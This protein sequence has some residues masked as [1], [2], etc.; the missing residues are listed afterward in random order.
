M[1]VFVRHYHSTLPVIR[2]VAMRIRET[3]RC[4]RNPFERFFTV[5]SFAGTT[6]LFPLRRDFH[7]NHRLPVLQCVKNQSHPLPLLMFTITRSY[8]ST[9]VRAMAI[10][11]RRRQQVSGGFGG[12]DDESTKNTDTET[13]NE[14]STVEIHPDVFL[15]LSAALFD[16]IH[17]AMLPLVPINEVMILTRGESSLALRDAQER[18]EHAERKQAKKETQFKKNQANDGD[19]NKNDNDNDDEPKSVQAIGEFQQVVDGPYLKI[20]LGPIHGQY[21]FIADTESRSIYFQ[22]PIS[23]NLIYHFDINRTNEWINIHDQHNLI[24]MFVRDI[25]RQIQGVPKL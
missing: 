25:I 7:A 5:R 13:T 9:H 24:G 17:Q 23:G 18:Q 19:E 15:S 21:T 2:S 6:A 16:S 4:N 3:G 10:G 1:S 11:R 8:S 12:I 14:K 22:S 20:E